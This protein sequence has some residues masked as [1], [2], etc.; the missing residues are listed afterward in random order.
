[1]LWETIRDTKIAYGVWF[2]LSDFEKPTHRLTIWSSSCEI[3]F[4]ACGHTS[5]S[6]SVADW[7]DD[8]NEL[9]A[10][11]VLHGVSVSQ[12]RTSVCWFTLAL[13]SVSWFCSTPLFT[14]QIIGCPKSRVCSGPKSSTYSL[15]IDG[16]T[17]GFNVP[18]FSNISSFLKCKLQILSPSVFTCSSASVHL[19]RDG[20]FVGTLR[21]REHSISCSLVAQISEYSYRY[22]LHVVLP[23]LF[24]HDLISQYLLRGFIFARCFFVDDNFESG[25]SFNC[26]AVQTGPS[27]KCHKWLLTAFDVSS[28]FLVSSFER[29]VR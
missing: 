2:W 14:L 28:V 7:A 15:K 25:K 13:I 24:T 11:S 16:T 22:I 18:F 12:S 23:R 19:C 26:W 3:C 1:M 6:G 27:S 4:A 8:T 10:C 20:S 17:C 9:V 21:E 29:S 5:W